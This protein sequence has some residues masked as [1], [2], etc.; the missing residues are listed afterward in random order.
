MKIRAWFKENKGLVVEALIILFVA[1]LPRLNGIGL[2]LTADEKNW[3]SRSNEYIKAWRHLRINDTLQTT[4][5][6]ITVMFV[7]GLAIYVAQLFYHMVFDASVTNG[8]LRFAVFAQVPMAVI[9]ALLVLAIFLVLRRLLP[10]FVAIVAGLVLALDPY[11][12]GFSKIVH[13]DAFLAGFLTL[14]IVLLLLYDK[15]KNKKIFYLAGVFAALA[16]L[17]KLPAIAVFPFVFLL[18]FF[19][20]QIFTKKVFVSQLKLFV[21]WSLFVGIIVV[22]LWPSLWWVPHPLD[23]ITQVQKDMT[24]ATLQ[25]HDMDEPY[26]ME[27]WHYPA[28]LLT[29]LTIPV[30]LGIILLVAM[31]AFR[32]SREYVFQIASKRLIIFLALFVLIFIAEMTIGAKKGDRY[33]LPVFPSIMILGMVGICAATNYLFKKQGTKIVQVTF[34]SAIIF[35]PMVVSLIKLGPYDLAYYNPLFSPSLSQ[36]VGWGEGFDQVAKYLNAQPDRDYVASW[37]PEELGALTKKT[38]LHINAHQQNRIGYVVLYRNMFGRNPDHW[39]NDFID[40]YYK[41]RT[42]VFVARVNGLEYAWVYKKPVVNAIVG[43]ILPGQAVIVKEALKA[44]NLSAVSV[45]VATYSGK[46]TEGSMTLHI[47]TDLSSP[48]LRTVTIDAKQLQD[49]GLTK[50]SFEPLS[51]VSGKAVYFIF[52]ANDT[53]TGNAPT[54]RVAKDEPNASYALIKQGVI[55]DKNFVVS[56]RPGWIGIDWFFIRDGKEI[57]QLEVK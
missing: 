7:A 25:P 48:D 15:T 21:F 8:L 35:I 56:T 31:L 55:N 52:T 51:G 28:T 19:N 57:S 33:V 34:A 22:L 9:N 16:I 18:L 6:G 42:P 1:L 32:K 10:R 45:A 14:S 40:E 47:K 43:E 20:K 49:G 27:V 37:Y 11:L 29:R 23:N 12:I 41:K 26:S 36:E 17:T 3:L 2:F 30:E 5:P 53:F 46:A 39:A 24:V 38:V 54:L 50:F 44:D 13:V 4:H